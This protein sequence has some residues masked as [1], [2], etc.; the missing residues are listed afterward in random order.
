MIII[1]ILLVITIYLVK[2]YTNKTNE[3][4]IE[5]IINK[6]KSDLEL[7]K[8]LSSSIEIINNDIKYIIDNNVNQH[9]NEMVT[10]ALKDGKRLRM[11][12][13]YSIVK[14]LN[15]NIK[16]KHLRNLNVIELIHN[17]SLIIDDLM[18]NDYYRRCNE[19]VFYKYGLSK[20]LLVT[21][22][23]LVVSIELMNNINNYLL[24]NNNGIHSNKLLKIVKKKI[25]NLID[26]Q[27]LDLIFDKKDK[28]NKIINILE[29]KTASLFELVFIMS[30]LL[31]K[32]D[33]NKINEINKIAKYF[34]LV[35]QIYD[36]FIDYYQ[37]KN[38]N[39]N[40]LI[41]YGIDNGYFDFHKYYRIVV[42]LLKENNIYTDEIN[43]IL[44]YLKNV[45]EETYYYIKY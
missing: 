29:G 13:G 21:F 20:S 6:V 11:I 28:S 9:F 36:D 34:G 30:W 18:D 42:K 32:G 5:K 12:I 4:N 25:K 17:A 39:L 43:I 40:Y 27:Y 38:K 45:V 26:G 8:K 33:N 2:Y 16:S 41:N 1:I 35:Y 14:K 15:P 19:T 10:Y 37:D 3:E 31:G 22:E 24:K 23:I 44:E 7:N